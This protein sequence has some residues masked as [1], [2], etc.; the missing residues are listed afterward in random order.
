MK[1]WLF[2]ISCFIVF[3]SVGQ[4]VQPFKNNQLINTQTTVIPDGLIL[5]FN[6]VLG[7]SP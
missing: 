5:Q 7:K 6:T 4:A 1:Y 3:T 2:F